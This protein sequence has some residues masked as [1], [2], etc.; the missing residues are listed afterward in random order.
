MRENIW[1]YVSLILI[2]LLALSIVSTALLYFQGTGTIVPKITGGGEVVENS[3]NVSTK[4]CP[5]Q[6]QIEEMEREIQFLKS[7]LRSKNIPPGNG[8]IAIVPIFGI[9]DDYTALEVVPL[10][11]ELA[12]NDSIAGVLL[13]IESPGGEVGPVIQIYDEVRKLNAL[14]PV[15]SYTGGIAASGGYY[16]AL[17]SEKIVSA[18][19]AQVGSIGVLYVHY[20]MEKNYQMN[21]I[22]VEVFRTGK[23]KD[24][25][26]E[27]RDLTPE[28]K[29]MITGMIN[30]YFDAFLTAFSRGRNLSMEKAKKYAT[31]ETW[32]GKDVNGTLIDETGSIDDAIELL[33]RMANV[34]NP[35]VKI[36]KGRTPVEFRVYGS[37]ALYLDPRY[38][39]K[40]VG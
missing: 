7:Q 30:E 18:P 15:V 11:R 2:L 24:M 17:G 27:W 31:G 38:L 23:H 20:D 1:K 22:K 9:I 8:T 29:E 35:N 21:G 14:K 5:S 40:S 28:E 3:I 39:G 34:T 4:N 13:W 16:I 25:G 12:K 32:L 19:L 36:Y 6:T 37:T 33:S 26:G 10:L